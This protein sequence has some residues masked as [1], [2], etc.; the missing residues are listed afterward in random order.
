MNK[1]AL[2]RSAFLVTN[3]SGLYLLVFVLLQ[4]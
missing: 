2:Q 4:R 3:F 1:K